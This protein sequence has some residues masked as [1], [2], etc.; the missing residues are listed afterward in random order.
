MIQERRNRE[1]ERKRER[2]RES[3]RERERERAWGREEKW[4]KEMK[5]WQTERETQPQAVQKRQPSG[6]PPL[7][8]RQNEVGPFSVFLRLIYFDFVCFVGFV[9][10]FFLRLSFGFVSFCVSV[11]VVCLCV[12]VWRFEFLNY[13]FLRRCCFYLVLIFFQCGKGEKKDIICFYVIYKLKS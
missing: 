5:D 8:S 12:C 7:D 9:F 1:R 11:C 10:V 6:V 13:N 4:N 2:E 3:E